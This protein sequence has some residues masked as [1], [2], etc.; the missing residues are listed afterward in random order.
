MTD[1]S[2]YLLTDKATVSPLDAYFAG[3]L[4]RLDGGGDGALHLAA[5]LASYSTRMGHVCL[6]LNA[7]AHDLMVDGLLEGRTSHCPPAEEW[8]AR[9][10]ATSVVGSEGSYRPLILDDQGRVYLYRYWTYQDRLAKWIGTRSADASLLV[11]L[12]RAERAAFQASL[13]R[14]FQVASKRG[15]DGEG[16]GIDWQTVAAVAAIRKRFCIISGGPGTGKTTV[17]CRILALLG[18]CL[19]NAD[20]KI[21]LAAPTGKA[22]ARLQEAVKR[23]KNFL[24][25]GQAVRDLIPET[26]T[27]IHRLLGVIPESGGFRHHRDNKLS[28]D[29]LVVDEASMVD[30]ALLSKLVQALGPA[31]RLILLGDKNQL[32]S[33]EAG[34]VLADIGDS[35]GLYAFSRAFRDE[36]KQYGGYDIAQDGGDE[37]ETGLQDCMVELRKSYRF[38]RQSGIR[39]VSDRVNDGD[40]MGAVA[41]LKGGAYADVRWA[42][43]P[44]TARLPEALDERAVDFFQRYLEAEDIEDAFARF[45]AFRI[46]CALREG[47]YG[48]RGVNG[49]IEERLCARGL[50]PAHEPWYRGRPVLVTR[51]DYTM[52]IFNGDVGIVW[53]E[54]DRM[55][56]FFRTVGGRIQRIHPA[57]LP[58]HETVYAMTVHKSQ[59]S[60]FDHVLFVLPDKEYPVVTRELIYT[61][62]TR[63]RRHVEIWAKEAV[64][65]SG[66]SRQ[67]RRMSGLRD[68]LW[69]VRT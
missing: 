57:R 20:L 67:T 44:Q 42:D 36:L 55:I 16:R 53:P 12:D 65:I 45:D 38:G 56:T 18:E 60:E 51:N 69:G 27:T 28:A 7:V 68:L 26:A 31:T 30:L 33:V 39:A 62:F 32:A 11:S 66:V 63:A 25:C 61:G 37:R 2:T 40:G 3:F 23:S 48:V 59:G 1:R 54:G 46:L 8:S 13:A 49:C 10:A 21:A 64:L 58:E 19:G 15:E 34:A 22:A 52:G 9:L 29:V 47:P 43:L 41:Q 5:A 35:R 24:N 6:D 4:S 14:L 50:I 17:V